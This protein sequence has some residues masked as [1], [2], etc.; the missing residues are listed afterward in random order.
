M[1]QD[2]DEE[3]FTSILYN[4]STKMTF[5]DAAGNCFKSEPVVI[6]KGCWSRYETHLE[7]AKTSVSADGKR[8]IILMKSGD[9][10]CYDIVGEKPRIRAHIAPDGTTRKWSWLDCGPS[11]EVLTPEQVA[12]YTLELRARQNIENENDKRDMMMR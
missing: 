1:I 8:K 12:V 2:L 4:N 5:V 3:E 11:I 7:G 6:K 9:K 10:V